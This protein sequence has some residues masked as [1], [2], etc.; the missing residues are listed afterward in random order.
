MHVYQSQS[1]NSSHLTSFP[2]DI[3]TFILCMCLSFCFV[4]KIIHTIFLDYHIISILKKWK[5][6][7]LNNTP[8]VTVWT[9]NNTLCLS[10]SC[11]SFLSLHFL[12]FLSFY[13]I[14]FCFYSLPLF[15]WF[16]LPLNPHLSLL[17][18]FYCAWSLH[19]SP[20][21]SHS[22]PLSLFFI[23]LF[24]YNEIPLMGTKIRSNLS[25]LCLVQW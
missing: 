9:N 11:F 1:P 25:L 12:C 20:C 24:S 22:F 21:S 8:K 18:F 5:L 2:P 17:S 14:S 3:H 4:N 13:F 6:K 10:F 19:F 15:S 7:R 16:T 23:S